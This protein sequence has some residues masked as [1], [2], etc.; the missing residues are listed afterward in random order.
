[1]MCRFVIIIEFRRLLA[2]PFTSDDLVSRCYLQTVLPP[3]GGQW[4]SFLDALTARLSTSGLGCVP[5]RATLP[6]GQTH[7][8]LLITL[9]NM[10]Y[11]RPLVEDCLREHEIAI[12]PPIPPQRW[13]DYA[14]DE[15]F[16]DNW[17]SPKQYDAA[18]L[19]NCIYDYTHMYE[20]SEH[21][22]LVIGTSGCDGIHFGYR[23][24]FPGL[25]AYYPG[26]DY[27]K[28]VAKSVAELAEGWRSAV[29]SV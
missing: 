27:F 22:F 3:P 4:Q 1:M 8:D 9:R 21:E 16:T 29:V 2:S 11:G 24:G 14:C 19:S 18:D 23:K 6:D 25:W 13:L 5:D 28:Q 10:E 26:E 12:Q 15:Y 17:W 7:D 20:D